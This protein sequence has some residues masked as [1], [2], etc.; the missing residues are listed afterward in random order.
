MNNQKPLNSDDTQLSK[1]IQ[2]AL[3]QKSTMNFIKGDRTGGG[4]L[5]CVTRNE[6]SRSGWQPPAPPAA[7][8]HLEFQ[9]IQP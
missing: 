6:R 1:I 7:V 8:H 9:Q 2:L 5:Q 3:S 4:M